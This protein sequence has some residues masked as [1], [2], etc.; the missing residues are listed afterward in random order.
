[1]KLHWERKSESNIQAKTWNHS[2]LKNVRKW[3]L[4]SFSSEPEFSTVYEHST[5]PWLLWPQL[6]PHFPPSLLSIKKH[7]STQATFSWY[8][9]EVT[10]GWIWPKKRTNRA[11][12]HLWHSCFYKTGFIGFM[13]QWG[14]RFFGSGGITSFPFPSSLAMVKDSCYFSSWDLFHRSLLV[15]WLFCYLCNWFPN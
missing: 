5:T 1:M 4:K 13:F 15:Y 12:C 7:G 11:Q 2:S 3:T 9:S 14:F 10:S 8:L 6:L